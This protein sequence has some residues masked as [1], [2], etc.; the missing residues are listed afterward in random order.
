MPRNHIR[1]PF[2]LSL[3][4]LP[5]PHHHPPPFHHPMAP[6]PPPAPVSMSTHDQRAANCSTS[7]LS[8]PPTIKPKSTSCKPQQLNADE[9]ASKRSKP[10]DAN[11]D[12][13]NNEG[14]KRG[15]DRRTEGAEREGNRGQA[16]NQEPRGPASPLLLTMTPRQP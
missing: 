11:A 6:S 16:E 7:V 15:A 10:T 2:F 5:F 8:A 3:P 1:W 12:D 4:H 9:S 14:G 13:D